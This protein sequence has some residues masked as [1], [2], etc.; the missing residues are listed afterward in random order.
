MQSSG[1]QR[2]GDASFGALDSGDRLVVP[3][4]CASSLGVLGLLLGEI[5]GA[6]H[7]AWSMSAPPGWR[8]DA[9]PDMV[10]LSVGKCLGSLMDKG[11][12]LELGLLTSTRERLESHPRLLRS[13]FFG[14]EDYLGCVYDVTPWVLGA[15]DADM[16]SRGGLV[17]EVSPPSVS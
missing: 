11:L 9:S 2:L 7:W 16:A 13:L 1:L 15:L 12:W 8:H 14:D 17:R 4:G 5:A 6:A 10:V 3:A